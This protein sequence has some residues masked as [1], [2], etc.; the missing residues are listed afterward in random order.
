MGK[1]KF[2]CKGVLRST[3]QR[4]SIMVSAD[5]KEA[6][7]QIANQHGVT[8]ESVTPVAEGAPEPPKAVVNRI[9]APPKPVATRAPE[10][11]KPVANRAPIQPKPALTP[12]PTAPKVAAKDLDACLDEILDAED[13]LDNGPDDFDLDDE[14]KIATTAP[15]PLATNACPYC[16]EQILAAAVKCK[17][18]GSYVGE[19]AAKASQPAASALSEEPGSYYDISTRLMSRSHPNP[20]FLL[21]KW[22]LVAAI[23]LKRECARLAEWTGLGTVGTV[24]LSAG[25]ACVTAAIVTFIRGYGQV[26]SVALSMLL[27]LGLTASVVGFIVSLKTPGGVEKYYAEKRDELSKLKEEYAGIRAQE[28]SQGGGTAAA[29]VPTGSVG[30]S[31][32]SVT[33]PKCGSSQITAQ[34][35]GFGGGS[36]CCGALLVGPLGLLCGLK[37][38]NKIVVTC[39]KCGHQWSRG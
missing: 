27:A 3:G 26:G 20:P 2:C 24:V 9:P 31:L 7:I 25:F 12:A 6:A 29:A 16:C 34:K 33:C 5:N 11:P 14:P 17:H 32:D 38:A 23:Y 36:A 8:V 4:A 15:D 18:C 1:Q 35:K 30:E 37:G 13:D 10:P 28:A 21:G 22:L 19:K 39:L